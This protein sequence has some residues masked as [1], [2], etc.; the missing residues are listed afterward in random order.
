MALIR[1]SEA[2]S[3]VFELMKDFTY[4][5]LSL[6]G[7]SSLT[8]NATVGDVYIITAVGDR[9]DSYQ[10]LFSSLDGAEIITETQ[11]V[12][13]GSTASNVRCYVA[14]IKATSTTITGTAVRHVWGAQVNN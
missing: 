8:I 6:P 11:M 12:Y 13:G 4:T 7:S 9:S 14:F 3:D 10:S 5:N 1:I 2:L